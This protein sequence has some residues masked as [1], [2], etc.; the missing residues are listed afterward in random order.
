L[1][2]NIV[3]FILAY[4]KHDSA[5]DNERI[6]NEA[7]AIQSVLW[8]RGAQLRQSALQFYNPFR[9]GSNNRTER[10]LAA[11]LCVDTTHVIKI[12]GPEWHDALHDELRQSGRADLFV[13]SERR[14]ELNIIIALLHTK[15]ID[16]HGLLVYPRI[17]NMRHHIQNITMRIEL[18]ES[19]F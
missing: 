16:T 2:I 18:A 19:V 7:C 14:N 1:P 17:V 13:P 4:A 10:K 3:A 5:I 12:S 11:K 8:P 15:P 9:M 6:F